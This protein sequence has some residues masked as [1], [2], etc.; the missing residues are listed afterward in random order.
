MCGE[1]VSKY[2]SSKYENEY[3]SIKQVSKYMI[4]MYVN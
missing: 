3:A 1:Y 4:S 2:M